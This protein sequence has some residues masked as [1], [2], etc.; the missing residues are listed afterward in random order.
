M[1]DFRRRQSKPRNPWT[2]TQPRD[3]KPEN[4]QNAFGR[5]SENKFTEASRK[6][7][8]AAQ[9]YVLDYDT[10]SEEDELESGNIIKIIL[11]DYT[12]TGAEVN[13]LKRTRGYLE[14]A[15]VSG[16]ATCLICISHIKR[17]DA[18]WNCSECYCSFHL[19]C[20]QRWSKDTIFN[21]KQLS[22]EHAHVRNINI[23][24]CCPKCR[25]EYNQKDIPTDYRC[26]CKKA[27]NPAYQYLLIPHS[28]GNT[29]RKE[30][31]PLCGH[32]CVLL[33][34]P[35]PCPPCPKTVNV[36]CY[37][38]SKPAKPQRCSNKDWSCGSPCNKLRSCNKHRCIQPCHRGDCEPCPKKSVQ[39]C[40]CGLNQKLR[41]CASPIWQCEK[42]CGKPL[43]CGH[44]NCLKI[45]HSG[46]CGPCELSEL[47]TCP[48]GKST[49]QLPCTE[50]TPTCDDTC[51]KILE[52]GQHICYQKCHKDKC[53]SCVETVV[54]SC[55]C[56]LHTKEIQCKKLYLCE[57][58]C[59]QM[60][61]CNKH[62]CNRK[63]CDGNCPQCEK[64]CGKTLSCGNHKCTSICHAG[65]CYPCQL[66]ENVYCRCGETFL[67]VPCGRKHKT[68][69]PKCLK[70]CSI[71]PECHHP[72]RENHRCHF[73][74]CP[75]CRQVCGKT[76]EKCSHICPKECH[77]SVLVKIEQKKASMPWEQVPPQL[78]KKSLPCPD[79]IVPVPVTCL[80]EHD[81]SDW[82]CY[83]AKPA[84]CGRP[85]GRLL[86]CG[87]HTCQMECHII[88][89]P[90]DI[91]R[92]GDNCEICTNPCTNLSVDGCIHQC[93]KACHPD[94][95]PPCTQII[96]IKCH[97]GL[98]QP[99]VA[100]KNWTSA[101]NKEELQSCGN[102]CP[103]NYE[104]G[105]RCRSNCHSGPCVS[106]EGCKKKVKIACPCKR[107]KK[108]FSCEIARQGLAVVNCDEICE[109][110][111][112]EEEKSRQIKF[113][114]KKK[115]KKSK[116]RRNWRNMKKYS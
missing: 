112:D 3:Q 72:K 31:K 93:T 7:Q 54:K 18:I 42:E 61:D 13:N 51:G 37:C 86:K 57:T 17:S 23:A 33:C 50:D 60:K 27:V 22:E 83:I 99:Y 58:K 24:W 55:R 87:N 59:K 45:C 98:N 36:S 47:R 73:G 76:H 32:E 101:E 105:H 82:P 92:A 79:C 2:I 96:R 104:C 44:H 62:P 114:Q 38:G 108:E 16:A 21:L 67:T 6:H 84:S 56:G 95:C 91:V 81:T 107:I 113:E 1:S 80:G 106:K 9:K 70:P 65:P 69:P 78:E 28:C 77:T 64:P 100:C 5:N 10:S 97:C 49:Y 46:N 43:D 110:K 115:K 11:K 40:I 14:D 41:D 68:R 75:P 34:H 35:G 26:F 48:C 52:C 25:K 29:C 8:A 4:I 20:I 74:D 89:G 71:P 90:H 63:C 102:Q 66:T 15:F 109:Q 19:M 85:C 103:N 111:K 116:T 12:S 53:G 94:D 30:L 39:K 88:E